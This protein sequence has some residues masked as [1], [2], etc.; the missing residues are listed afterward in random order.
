MSVAEGDVKEETPVN[1]ADVKVEP[2]PNQIIDRRSPSVEAG[3]DDVLTI[4]SVFYNGKT[5]KLI[6]AG[7]KHIYNAAFRVLKNVC[8]AV[9]DLKIGL[10]ARLGSR[11]WDSIHHAESGEIKDFTEKYNKVA[12]PFAANWSGSY[13]T[14]V[15][16]EWGEPNCNARVASDITYYAYECAVPRP[17]HLNHYYKS[18]TS[19][20]YGETNL[21]QMASIIEELG[22][23]P[24]DVFVDLGSGI[25]QLVCFTAAFAKCK[26]SIGIELSD[27]PADIA[28][29]L[30]DY[31]KRFGEY[32]KDINNRSISDINAISHTRELCSLES[33]VSWTA[34][35]VKFY[36]T[37]MDHTKLI[38]YYE[39]ERKKKNDPNYK[40]PPRE[41][42]YEVNLHALNRGTKRRERKY[43]NSPEKSG[44]AKRAAQ[45]SQ[46]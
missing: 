45:R 32:K 18:F 19:E 41:D 22:V 38:R 17:Q 35:A 20:T 9:P 23:G 37:T 42:F 2:Q 5:L 40:P 25:G 34:K 10:E 28:A 39:E 24:H 7:N 13:N 36:V 1:E 21:E 43:E 14:D 6:P 46:D 11:K 8:A 27:T 15:L 29:N 16:K 12:K 31:F 30:G 3:Q 4:H 44:R 26:K 33:G